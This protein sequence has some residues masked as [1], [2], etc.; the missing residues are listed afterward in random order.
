MD[1]SE[2]LKNKLESNKTKLVIEL[3]ALKELIDF[4]YI[5]THGRYAEDGTLQG[6]LEILGCKT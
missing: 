5:A 3:Q 2:L 6:F 4:V 1:I